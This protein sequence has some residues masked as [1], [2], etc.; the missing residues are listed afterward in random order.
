VFE[1]LAEKRL[2]QV[3]DKEL[4]RR[5]PRA[6]LGFEDTPNRPTTKAKAIDWMLSDTN[7]VPYIELDE[8]SLPRR[9]SGGYHRQTWQ[10]E[11][12]KWHLKNCLKGE[13][14]GL[15]TSSQSSDTEEVN[16]MARSATAR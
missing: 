6:P 4:V 3:T 15:T 9:L 13:R 10:K 16:R 14:S 2:E 12:I 5:A 11:A 8:E 7:S 1:Q